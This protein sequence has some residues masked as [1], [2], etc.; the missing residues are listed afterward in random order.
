FYATNKYMKPIVIQ[1]TTVNWMTKG[2]CLFRLLLLEMCYNISPSERLWSVR[3]EIGSL[4]RLRLMLCRFN[5]R[6]QKTIT[7][8]CSSPIMIYNNCYIY[9]QNKCYSMMVPFIFRKKNTT[10]LS[11]K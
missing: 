11:N 2:I 10:P 8:N 3:D 1:H 9:T 5:I 4:P 6:Y 7:M